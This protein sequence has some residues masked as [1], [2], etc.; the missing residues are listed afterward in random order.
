MGRRIHSMRIVAL[1]AVAAGALTLGTAGVAVASAP[2]PTL[3]SSSR[4]PAAPAQLGPAAKSRVAKFSCTRAPRALSRIEN[5]EARIAAG[6]PKLHAAEAKATAAGKTKR[7]AR[8]GKTI[9]RLSRPGVTA[10]LQA[11]ASA[12]GAKCG[13]SAPATTPTT[14]G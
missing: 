11:L 12:I 7:A 6:L 9:T 1:A 8:I 4:T 13:V 3:T 14:G 5:T 2:T 10:R